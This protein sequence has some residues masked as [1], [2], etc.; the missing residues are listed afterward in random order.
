MGGG[1]PDRRGG[2]AVN[3][4]DPHLAVRASALYLTLVVTIAL[5]LWRRPTRRASAG[6]MLACC[7]NVPVVLAL[8]IAAS[9]SGW[10][11][12]D[13]AGGLFMGLPVDLYIAWVLLWGA[14]PALAFPALPLWRVSLIAL[15]FDVVRCRQPG[16]SSISDRRG[17][18]AKRLD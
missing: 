5:W 12:F 4:I 3:G 1:L 9:R 14:L 8:H 13:A 7:W 11:W 17:S 16:P 18:P 6:A 2:D 10:W 15:A